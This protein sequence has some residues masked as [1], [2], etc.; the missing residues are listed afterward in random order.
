MP[1]SAFLDAFGC[2]SS[3]G[4]SFRTGGSAGIASSGLDIASG[5]LGTVGASS[6]GGG[7]ADGVACACDFRACCFFRS[8]TAFIKRIL[9]GVMAVDLCEGSDLMLRLYTGRGLYSGKLGMGG[10]TGSVEGIVV[11]GSI[12]V[13][14]GPCDF[15]LDGS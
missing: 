1:E 3:R 8:S 15:G 10:G 2:S 6:A 5:T 13:G 12:G 9:S 14:P 4:S 11:V 7:V